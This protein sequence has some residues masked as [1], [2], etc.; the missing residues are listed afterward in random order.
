MEC[1]IVFLWTYR[2][3]VAAV[4]IIQL[5]VIIWYTHWVINQARKEDGWLRQMFARKH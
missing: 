2:W 4:V 5:S 3:V 1:L